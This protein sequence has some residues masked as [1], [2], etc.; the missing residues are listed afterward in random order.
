MRGDLYLNNMISLKKS[1]ITF[2]SIFP[3]FLFSQQV[4][5][6]SLKGHWVLE[7]AINALDSSSTD[8][9]Y[10]P[11]GKYLRYT[12][13]TFLISGNKKKKKYRSLLSISTSPIER[14]ISYSYE[15][16][17]Q[18]IKLNIHD[19]WGA[20]E[21]DFHVFQISDSTLILETSSSV[22]SKIYYFKK[23]KPGLG[24]SQRVAP[25][26]L[27]NRKNGIPKMI[28][29]H[30]FNISSYITL[31]PTYISKSLTNS[32][33][34]DLEKSLKFPNDLPLGET[35]GPLN[36]SIKIKRNGKVSSVDADN[37]VYVEL[38]EQI[39]EFLQN[40]EWHFPNSI[41]SNEFIIQL[42]I[43]YRYLLR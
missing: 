26:Y 3:L 36:I 39:K 38:D 5:T 27:I 7:K 42:P 20:G 35:K 15:L 32:L 40:S 29:H 11:R 2:I 37:N 1:I 28:S 19:S 13:D 12:F 25:L 9:K 10:A 31:L 6:L 14:G 43:Y 23:S 16:K 24:N 17:G 22:Q 41:Q 8:S 18:K 4:D 34:S 33:R 21:T 30:N